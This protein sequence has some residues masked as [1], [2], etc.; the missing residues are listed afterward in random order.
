[1]VLRLDVKIMGRFKIKKDE[2]FFLESH[3][4]RMFRKHS[5]RMKKCMRKSGIKDKTAFIVTAVLLKC[6]EVEGRVI[7]DKP[8]VDWLKEIF[9]G[10]A[11]DAY[12]EMKE[13][14]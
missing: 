11:K 9:G 3:S 14:R 8:M 10:N 6:D 13:K 4:F 12:E 5:I 1:M 2:T 7:I